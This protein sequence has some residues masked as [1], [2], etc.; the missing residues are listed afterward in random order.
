MDDVT[1]FVK[2]RLDEDVA[3][4]GYVE[5]GPWTSSG[6]YVGS[7][8]GIIAQARHT[9]T[10]A[11]IA[12][13]DPARVLREVA[14]KRAIVAAYAKADEWVNVSAGATAAYARQIMDETLRHL[15]AVWSDHPDYR[16]EWAP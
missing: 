1:A 6:P 5:P 9:E 16:Q 3:A 12:R 10:G 2:A 14:A 8:A 13:H 7:A 15:A 11:H 4:L